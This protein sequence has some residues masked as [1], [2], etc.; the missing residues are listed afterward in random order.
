MAGEGKLLN[1]Y[2]LLRRTIDLGLAGGVVELGC[3]AG[4]TAC[5]L[6]AVLVK[7]K[8]SHL[9]G[10]LHLYDSF[11]GLPPGDAR[12]D[13]PA[14]AICPGA[15]RAAPETVLSNFASFGLSPPTIHVGWFKDSCSGDGLPAKIAFAHLDGDL[16][17]SILESLQVVYPR[18]V[19]GAIVVVDDFCDP[20]QLDRH[21][22]FPG[23]FDACRD[24]FADK[25]EQL[26]VLPAPHPT[27]P[28]SGV[29]RTGGYEC[30]AYFQKL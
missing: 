5:M 27:I 2:H 10:D 7:H 8:P 26:H 18:L 11:E 22:I 21:N 1:L 15:M 6:Q 25:P 16:Y 29:D 20:G 28:N 17:A 30:H 3:N 12:F 13:P 23:A 4:V 19:P 24:F 14:Y 9:P